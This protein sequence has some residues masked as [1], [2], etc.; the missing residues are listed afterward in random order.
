MAWAKPYYVLGV[1]YRYPDSRRL[2]AG[3]ACKRWIDSGYNKS[4]RIDT[5]RSMPGI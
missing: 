5:G 1:Q 4:Y 2:A 3:T